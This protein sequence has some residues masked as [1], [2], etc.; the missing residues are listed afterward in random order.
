MAADAED[1]RRAL[2]IERWG[3]T[4]HGTLSRLALEIVRRTPEHVDALVLDTPS[5]PEIDPYT[6]AIV[7]TREAIHSLASACE[8]QRAC[9]RAFPD[10]EVAIGEALDLLRRDPVTLSG[11]EGRSIVMDDVLF[12][13]VLRQMLTQHDLPIELAP[14]LVYGALDGRLRDL[15]KPIVDAIASDPSYCLGYH[16]KC[17]QGDELAEGTEY[18]I[19]CS[20]V[21]PFVD[22]AALQSTANGE[23]SYA[24]AFAASPYLDVCD[25][26]PVAA[27]PSDVAEPVVT[28]V[29]TLA[30][31][32][33]FDPYAATEEATEQ[34]IGSFG[35]GWI[36]TFPNGGHNLLGDECPRAVRNAWLQR[37]TSA[38]TATDCINREPPLR[39]V[40]PQ[41]D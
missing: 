15:D 17:L 28:D 38:P 7:G 32:G 36:V 41:P 26:W 1:L 40:I 19:L 9:A 34:A 11:S 10:L 23:A 16:P 12:L 27:S 39:F 5:F 14:S 25:S 6:E 24:G 22:R 37:P 2:D 3:I 35:R 29:P 13:R 21:V 8:A 33:G 31:I 4:T 18:S 20:N 30:L